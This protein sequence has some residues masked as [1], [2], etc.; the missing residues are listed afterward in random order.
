MVCSACEPLLKLQSVLESPGSGSGDGGSR[1]SSATETRLSGEI[2]ASVVDVMF[3]LS[4]DRELGLGQDSR[5]SVEAGD[6][7]LYIA[8]STQI[9][10]VGSYSNC[11]VRCC[12]AG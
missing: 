12:H 5:E 9:N 6:V 2:S 1:L 8:K 3:R 4:S 10:C 11:P 7:S